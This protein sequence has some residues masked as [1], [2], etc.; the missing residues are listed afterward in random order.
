[1]RYHTPQAGFSLV[2]TLVAITILLLVI[3]GPM[4]ISTSTARS[5]SFS[6]EQVVAF[7]LAQEGAELAQK[8]RDDLVVPEFTNTPP[9][10]GDGWDDFAD[11][12]AGGPY[13]HCFTTNGCGL[14]LEPTDAK[15]AL[16]T[17]QLCSGNNCQLYYNAGG[18]RARYTHD[19]AHPETLYTRQIFF[20]QV[21]SAPVHEVRVLSRVTWRTGSLREVQTVEVETYLFN[22][23]ENQP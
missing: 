10:P 19:S 15:G 13:R 6:S 9:T 2:E 21:G 16:D 4:T 11:D 5:T 20:E 17:V 22:V 8:A 3:I 18:E 12:G 23:Y 14:E 7:F 1:M